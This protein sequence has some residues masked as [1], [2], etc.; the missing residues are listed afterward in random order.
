MSAAKLDATQAFQSGAH[1]W[2]IQN[3]P[4]LYW[5]KKL[6]LHSRYLL[7]QNILKPKKETPVQLQNILN[8]T[9]MD[10]WKNEYTK[11]SLLLG[12]EDHFQNK[13]L[14]L[15]DSFTDAQLV[16]LV[17]M[18]H[19]QLRAESIRFF[20][21]S[22]VAETISTRPMASSISISYIENS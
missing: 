7:S 15:W 21:H 16:T 4:E 22:H 18:I 2:I 8:A 5:W 20:S 19:T 1:L 13:W 9:D 10:V 6:D 11:N 17:E 12:T 14:L 3:N